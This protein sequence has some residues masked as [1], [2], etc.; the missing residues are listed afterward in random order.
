MGL[1]LRSVIL[2]I[3]FLVSG[4]KG[5]CQAP[6]VIEHPGFPAGQTAPAA[7]GLAYGNAVY[8]AITETGVAYISFDGD[9]WSFSKD[10]NVSLKS[11][12]FG[13]GVFVA[14]GANGF[15]STSADGIS[16]TTRMSGTIK[17]LNHVKYLHGKFYAV[18]AGGTALISTDAVEW[19]PI[20]VVAGAIQYE[21]FDIEYGNGLYMIGARR[22]ST[23][24]HVIYSATGLSNSWTNRA[25]PMMVPQDKLHNLQ[26]LKDRFFLFLKSGQILTSL[27]GSDW[28][29][30]SGLTLTV[31]GAKASTIA[32][33]SLLTHGVSDGVSVFLFGKS[34]HFG[35][36]GA[37]FK[38]DDMLAFTLHPQG[39]YVVSEDAG[40]I[41]GKYFRWGQGIV[42]SDNGSVY[43]FPGGSFTSIAFNGSGYVMTGTGVRDG[44]IFRSGDF[45]TVTNVTPG[46]TGALTSVVYNGTKFLAVGDRAVW[47]SYDG[48]SWNEA[49]STNDVFYGLTFG[50]SKFVAVGFQS[51]ELSPMISWSANGD[52]WNVVNSDNNQYV[53]V[54]YVNGRFFALGYNNSTYEGVIYTST[55]GVSWSN[56]SPSG[57][58][59]TVFSYN[60][61]VWDGSKYHFMGMEYVGPKDGFQ[62]SVFTISSADP[63]SS[64]GYAE[65]VVIS[66]VPEGVL[67]GSLLGD[68]VFEF[69]KGQFIGVVT[70]RA[71][72][73]AYVIWS[74]DGTQWHSIKTTVK[75][76]FFGS[77][78]NEGKVRFAGTNNQRLTIIPAEINHPPVVL[79]VGYSQN[80]IVGQELAG[81]YT[82]TDADGD[83]EG[84]SVY[85]W[86]RSDDASGTGRTLIPG[87]DSGIYRLSEA[88]RG[89]YIS[90][91]VTPCDLQV[92]GTP[93]MGFAV[94][95]VTGLPIITA[96]TY[97]AET[98]KLNVS[99]ADLPSVPGALNDIVVSRLA[100]S[101]EQGNVH[102]LTSADVDITDSSSFSIQ[103]NTV[104]RNAVQILFNKNGVS[105][106]A[107]FTYNLAAADGW[108]AGVNDSIDI[109]DL[110]SNSIVVSNRDVTPPVLERVTLSADTLTT[111]M[112]A[113]VTFVFSEPVT[114]F[115]LEALTA[116]NGTLS[117]LVS[118][119]GGNT[120]TAAL[121]PAPNINSA[122]NVITA[123]MSG[124][125][126]F[127]GNAGMGSVTSP[128]YSVNTV[129]V[130]D[131]LPP[132]INH[133]QL[134]NNS[135]T[136]G[137][138][139]AVTF[140]FSEQV[141]GFSL[142]DMI[143]ENG[144]LA[145]LTT[146]D[147]GVTW[148]ATLV[149][150][151]NVESNSNTISI[152][153]SG[154]ADASGNVGTG[155]FVSPVY[156]VYTAAPARAGTN[157]EANGINVEGHLVQFSTRYGVPSSVQK[158][159]VSGAGL[160]TGIVITS[161]FGFEV[162][163]DGV[164]FGKSV[165]AGTG[166]TVPPTDVLV[167]LS[168]TVPV[169]SYAGNFSIA[170]DHFESLTLSSAPENIVI[171]AILNVN[172]TALDKVY[173]GNANATVTLVDNRTPGDV[174]NVSYTSAFFE[175]KDAGT[176]KR[177]TVTGISIEGPDARNY[178]FSQTAHSAAAIWRKELIVKAEDVRMFAGGKL[179]ELNIVYSGF[180]D[181][182][183]EAILVTRPQVV[184]AGT[185]PFA[186]GKYQILISGASSQNYSLTYVP[187]TLEV[188]PA[189]P[190]AMRFVQAP[191][192][193]NMPA[194]TIAG[195]LSATSDS[196]DT[197]LTYTLAGGNDGTDNH[198]FRISGN[199]LH[200]ASALDFEQKDRY[201]VR[202]RSTDQ[203][204]VSIEQ[205][206]AIVVQDV[207][208]APTMD[209]IGDELVCGNVDSKTIQLQ[210]IS[211]GPERDQT[212]AFSV[213]TTNSDL[214]AQLG[215]TSSGRL[216]Y[217]VR[218]GLTGT[219]V[220]TVTVIDNGGT[221]HGGVDNISR[222][223]SVTANPMLVVYIASDKGLSVSKGETAHLTAT[224]GRSYRWI[225]TEGVVSG[226]S[227]NMLT[228]RPERT[229]TYRVLVSSDNGCQVEQ[230]I[231]IEV[232]EDY[233]TLDRTN[234]LTPNGD[235]VNDAFI[236]KNIDM[237][238]NHV[239]KIFDRA[240]RI[241]YTKAN[242]RNEWDGTLNG[243]PL[244]G[245]TYYY[246]V[247]FGKGKPVLK[248]FITV[249]RD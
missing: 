226:E 5:F 53:K 34:N 90:F 3:C 30:I 2:S 224:G 68:G 198:L 249:I 235:G 165:V 18:G 196:P 208:E 26:Y 238:Q 239:L 49:T 173:D 86:Y 158:F 56:V 112:S 166:G 60:D 169:G 135:L 63:T 143:V 104:D 74:N 42:S 109:A 150:A 89:K 14:V 149:P 59:D 87:A 175:S 220:V 154:V 230:E 147:N 103:L 130:R 194:G 79:N 170:S 91:E 28:A 32:G 145:A 31:P 54:K 48:N 19:T 133:F 144:H 11:L 229:T 115:S 159:T 36:E 172:A 236:I 127:A 207:N 84:Y 190:S 221:S 242:Y 29:N 46:I 184:A 138:T 55:D 222:S 131:T 67:L 200:T 227:T 101:G 180:A 234:I 114:G 107:G 211:A 7:R 57:L 128:N 225:H 119:D 70:D 126:D 24:A 223:F 129:I 4:F 61:V 40:Y 100:L 37:V 108:A 111:G 156:S 41:N 140:V 62:V 248:G 93:A 206:F 66:G 146:A 75:S 246:A 218:P 210:G 179:P 199:Y 118:I 168:G 188:L 155:M 161:P 151:E 191:L 186:P 177:V 21:F 44:E 204:G 182:E 23:G 152:M 52:Q 47:E 43:K 193:E 51:A 81:S 167:R 9:A 97:D 122:T 27:N 189:G 78:V 163:I 205:V 214:F 240:G 243:S 77:I 102:Q 99:G 241:L 195:Q 124:V 25:L 123:V 92:Y 142:E 1:N 232:K 12:A 202:V 136:R 6:A 219:A 110:Y 160:S 201:S 45:E 231:T 185:S 139:A 95:P 176:Q 50:A 85:R 228:V 215:I 20:A 64:S 69:C 82:F 80:I 245:G 237:Y 73:F 105:S 171:P 157:P 72:G 132:V 33:G 96:A 15:I 13:N 174:F 209:A 120:W 58:S 141:I 83:R 117:E 162:S 192:F 164:A 39:P 216:T 94:G 10:L 148:V 35:T 244:P 203:T 178:T 125:F 233:L 88:D 187:G 217:Q 76:R 8:V 153:M 137:D 98:G 247:D 116:E 183:N 16:W 17:T 134:S 197:V 71:S 181:G 65:K 213:T 22:L 113:T 121:A 38:S 212:V 106:A